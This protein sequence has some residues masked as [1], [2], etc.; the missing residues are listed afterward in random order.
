LA[1]RGN[2]EQGRTLNVVQVILS[3]TSSVHN[4]DY[5][6]YQMPAYKDKFNNEEIAQLTNFIM[7][8]SDWQN[9]ND[10]ITAQDIQKLKDGAP[11]IKGWP[12][13][14]YFID[15]I[16]ILI[17]I[18]LFWSYKRTIKSKKIKKVKR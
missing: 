16:G 15:F 14:I 10:K 4:E 11:P 2:G 7:H 13:I 12:V 1:N 5:I 3:G 9:Y 8:N 18:G 6:A 17:V